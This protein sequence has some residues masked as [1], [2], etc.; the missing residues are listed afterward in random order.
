[1]AASTPQ[2]EYPRQTAPSAIRHPG[3]CGERF[4]TECCGEAFDPFVTG[5]RLRNGDYLCHG[6]GRRWRPTVP[7]RLA[8]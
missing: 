2:P 3:A 8:A 1:M 7:S 6:C 4:R 5:E